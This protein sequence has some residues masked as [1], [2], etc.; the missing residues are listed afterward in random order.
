M[1][2]FQA[3]RSQGNLSK[4]QHSWK[5]EIYHK[6]DILAQHKCDIL[7]N[8][9]MH[10]QH[11]T[12]LCVCKV[13]EFPYFIMEKSWNLKVQKEHGPFLKS[14]IFL[15]FAITLDMISS[16]H[17]TCDVARLWCTK[18]TYMLILYHLKSFNT[19]QKKNVSSK[20][21]TSHDR[22]TVHYRLKVQ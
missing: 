10:T 15:V 5:M 7:D 3:L 17:I 13:M 1:T 12:S 2:D 8:I 9:L 6:S 18:H 14:N 16:T 19:E 4:C 22:Q 11:R 20:L 21:S